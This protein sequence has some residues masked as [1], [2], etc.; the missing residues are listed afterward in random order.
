LEDRTAPATTQLLLD[1]TPDVGNV[2]QPVPFA[3]L[4]RARSPRSL[5]FLDVNHDGRANLKDARI[6]AER[7]RRRVEQLLAPFLPLGVRVDVTD[8]DGQTDAAR[9][10]LAAGLQS[11]DL[12]VDVLFIGGGTNPIND[13]KGEATIARDGTNVEG[14]GVV[15][16]GQ[17]AQSVR[18]LRKTRP[19]DFVNA[20]AALAAHE[21]GHLLGLRHSDA[22]PD[23]NLMNPVPSRDPGRRRFIDAAVPTSDGTSQNAVAELIASFQGQPPTYPRSQL[24]DIRQLGLT[25][26]AT[27]G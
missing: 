25:P 15:H 10:A 17:I 2:I 7:V 20:V 19:A 5:R 23:D 24:F 1:F 22:F 12:Q 26:P 3:A 21:F 11:R 14:F 13:L 9:Q 16:G 8:V 18:R 27:T 4:F 6:T